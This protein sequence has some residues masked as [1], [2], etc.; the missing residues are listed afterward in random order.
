M[1]AAK[2]ILARTQGFVYAPPSAE[3]R[4]LLGLMNALDQME[5]AILS[6]HDLVRLEDEEAAK[7][8]AFIAAR[9]RVIAAQLDA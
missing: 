9:L 8:R 7:I 2:R 5:R 3:Y 6:D 1:D 4:Q